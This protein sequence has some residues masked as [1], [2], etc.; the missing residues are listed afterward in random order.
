MILLITC[1]FA[2]TPYVSPL[3]IPFEAFQGMR[4]QMQ[5]LLDETTLNQL[6]TSLGFSDLAGQPAINKD[7][8]KS[9]GS[10]VYHSSAVI[11]T[12]ITSSPTPLP[13]QISSIFRTCLC[14]SSEDVKSEPN[15]NGEVMLVLRKAEAIP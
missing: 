15:V 1:I 13:L 5:P 6:S 9:Q 4:F 10:I 14:C 11:Y 8:R 12:W 2:I 3:R 7:T